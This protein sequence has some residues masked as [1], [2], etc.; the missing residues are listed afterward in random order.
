[1]SAKKI[2]V[3]GGSK[4]FGKLMVGC[5]LEAGNQ[6]SLATR[7]L[8]DD[9]FGDT[10]DRICID[11]TSADS[12]SSQ[13]GKK[14]YDIVYDQIGYCSLDAKNLHRALSGKIGKLVFMSSG[15]VYYPNGKPEGANENQQPLR[16]ENFDPHHQAYEIHN[17]CQMSYGE[18]KR[19][20]E[21]YYHQQ[22]SYPVASMR[23]PIVIGPT[24]YTRRLL[25]F[26]KNIAEGKSMKLKPAN[27][28]LSYISGHDAGRLLYWA[29]VNDISGPINGA[30]EK[31]S[32]G[33]LIQ[34]A[35]QITGG[36]ASI[37]DGSGEEECHMIDRSSWL[38]PSLAQSAG[39][40]YENLLADDL[41]ET[42]EH[43]DESGS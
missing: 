36:D 42:W 20:S 7:G 21:C 18:G 25:N 4:F 22:L 3:L 40:K 38:D 11:R 10:V 27:T 35:A 31:I 28:M 8:L 16:E 14:D 33:D 43:S 1:M 26:M 2:L 32:L 6:V 9:G 41:R 23:F 5:H 39:F 30:S 37:Q 24:D 13:L 15:A 29:G 12:L 17:A 19:E 34:L